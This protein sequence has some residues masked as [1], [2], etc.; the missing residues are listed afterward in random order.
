MLNLDGMVRIL[1]DE[2]DELGAATYMY[3]LNLGRTAAQRRFLRAKV[4]FLRLIQIYILYRA[5][6][7]MRIRAICVGASNCR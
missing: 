7:C 6:V 3:A 2:S 4:F 1:L 5:L